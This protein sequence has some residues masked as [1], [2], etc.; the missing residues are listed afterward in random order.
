MGGGGRAPAASAST[1][2]IRGGLGVLGSVPERD[3]VAAL[4]LCQV[5]TPVIAVLRITL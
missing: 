5:G 2:S 3:K 1:R 4:S